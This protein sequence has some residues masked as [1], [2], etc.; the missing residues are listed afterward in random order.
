MDL[1]TMSGRSSKHWWLLSSTEI[2]SEFWRVS[3]RWTPAWTGKIISLAPWMTKAGV[4]VRVGRIIIEFIRF[5]FL[6]ILFRKVDFSPLSSRLHQWMRIFA[7]YSMPCKIPLSCCLIFLGM[8]SSIYHD[9]L[10]EQLHWRSYY[11]M[12]VAIDSK[13]KLAEF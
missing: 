1:A 6:H 9:D 12:K 11:L 10:D 5:K 4:Y 2:K 7:V 13:W 8:S 3:L